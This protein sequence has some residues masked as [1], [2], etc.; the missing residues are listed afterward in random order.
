MTLRPAFHALA[1]AAVLL[2]QACP[3]PFQPADVGPVDVGEVVDAAEGAGSDADQEAA[4]DDGLATPEVL[5]DGTDGDLD[6]PAVDAAAE[7]ETEMDATEVID[8]ATDAPIVVDVDADANNPDLQPGDACADPDLTIKPGD[9]PMG[10]ACATPCPAPYPCTC[11]ECPWIQTPKL[12]LPRYRGAGL[13]TGSEVLVFGGLH[14]SSDKV[15]PLTGERWTPGKPGG[16]RADPDRQ[17]LAAP[18]SLQCR[19]DGNRGLRQ[20]TGKPA[21]PLQSGDQPDQAAARAAPRRRAAG[22]GRRQA[23]HLGLRPGN[24]SVAQEPGGRTAGSRP[25]RIV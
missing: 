18:V 20:W 5:Q 14:E 16:G 22:L 19:L 25:S 10:A 24:E 17:V 4:A 1:V 8:G 6:G 2:L 3:R 12:L 21:V 11:G 23:V 7:S 13:W 15:P 9:P